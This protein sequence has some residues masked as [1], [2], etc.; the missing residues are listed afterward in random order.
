MC[1]ECHFV[2][3]QSREK[4]ATALAP[5]DKDFAKVLFKEDAAQFRVGSERDLHHFGLSVR[6]GGEIE[7]A[8]ARFAR[9]QVVFAVV[10]D[11]RHVEALDIARSSLAIAIDH[12]IYS[13]FVVFLKHGALRFSAFERSVSPMKTFSCTRVTL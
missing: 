4:I 11:R 10:R 6:V 7:H 9:C 3:V 1:L 8:A 13:A 12:I 2:N 5:L